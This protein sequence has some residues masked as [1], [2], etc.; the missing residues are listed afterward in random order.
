MVEITDKAEKIFILS[1]MT[2][3]LNNKLDPTTIQQNIPNLKL[4]V[5]YT[6]FKRPDFFY[7]IE[8]PVANEGQNAP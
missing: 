2:F 5:G 4:Y 1:L 6:C 8:D 7:Q 3:H